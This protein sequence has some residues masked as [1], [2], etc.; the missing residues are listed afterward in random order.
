MSD[1]KL[2]ALGVYEKDLIPMSARLLEVASNRVRGI[3]NLLTSCV[4]TLE[5]EEL[6]NTL[7]SLERIRVQL[8]KIDSMIRDV[9]EVLSYEDA[10]EEQPEPEE[11]LPDV[12]EKTFSELDPQELEELKKSVKSYT[13]EFIE[14]MKGLEKI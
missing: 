5:E 7:E 3:N 2:F 13:E 9:Q 10:P 8:I 11:P 1:E 6:G 12:T 4:D 14:Q